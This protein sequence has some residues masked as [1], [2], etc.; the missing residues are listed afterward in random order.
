MSSPQRIHVRLSTHTDTHT[1]HTHIDTHTVHTPHKHTQHMNTPTRPHI[2]DRLPHTQHLRQNGD[3]IACRHIDHL[4]PHKVQA[5]ELARNMKAHNS[6]FGLCNEP[7]WRHSN[8]TAVCPRLFEI[9][10]TL[11]FEAKKSHCVTNIRGHHK[12]NNETSSSTCGRQCIMKCQE[13]N[14]SKK[15]TLREKKIRI[16]RPRRFH[17]KKTISVIVHKLL[18]RGF[19]SITVFFNQKWS[20]VKLQIL[21]F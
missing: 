21:L 4:A 20:R 15:G 5:M 18:R 14:R 2:H 13:H 3:N 6:Q 19:I 17:K 8:M 9:L 7:H 1:T 11:T 12:K 16:R 10:T